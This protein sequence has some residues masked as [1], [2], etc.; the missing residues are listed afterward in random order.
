[1]ENITVPLAVLRYDGAVD[2]PAG[3]IER[4]DWLINQRLL[5]ATS[6]EDARRWWTRKVNAK[7]ALAG[8]SLA[9]VLLAADRLARELEAEER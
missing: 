1:M 8:L 7:R 9:Q 5:G 2:T 3:P 4:Y 6:P